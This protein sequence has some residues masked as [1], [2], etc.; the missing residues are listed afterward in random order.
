MRQPTPEQAEDALAP[1]RAELLRAA[2]ADAEAVLA[3]A[4]REAGRLL[5]DARDE[6]AALLEEARRQGEADAAAVR[7]AERLR[8]RR[9]L[10]CAVLAARREAWEELCRQVVSGVR[11]LRHRREHPM[12]QWRLGVHAR[13]VLGLGIRI[14][15]DP[16]GGVIGEA[17]GR[18][19]DCTLDALA[20]HLVER[21]S[22]EVESLWTP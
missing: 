12:V 1:V 7:S 22:A 19:V 17:S 6:A 3:E 20:R 9:S 2:R 16:G 8:T 11:E 14:T 18:R 21:N 4:G 13:S 15:E 10:R 5:A